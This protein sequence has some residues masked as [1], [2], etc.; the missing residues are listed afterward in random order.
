[1][2]ITLPLPHRGSLDVVLEAARALSAFVPMF[3]C[4]VARDRLPDQNTAHYGIR[5]V[6]INMYTVKSERIIS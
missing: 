4:Q 5:L 3:C 6:Y 2:R 1:M